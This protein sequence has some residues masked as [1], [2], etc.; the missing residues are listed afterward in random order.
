MKSTRNGRFA[1]DALGTGLDVLSG[2]RG[3]T[4]AGFWH[5]PKLRSMV[6]FLLRA[7]L[8][9]GRWARHALPCTMAGILRVAVREGVDSASGS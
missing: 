4:S 1:V 9:L 8:A 2:A 7:D 3:D 6:G 5:S